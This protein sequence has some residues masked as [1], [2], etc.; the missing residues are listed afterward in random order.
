MMFRFLARVR[1]VAVTIPVSTNCRFRQVSSS[2]WCS[3][4]A[5]GGAALPPLVDKIEDASAASV[6]ERNKDGL[7]I[8][9]KPREVVAALDQFIVGQTVS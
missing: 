1:G 5:S 2:R 8:A 7:R 6:Q 9:L 4:T 3:T